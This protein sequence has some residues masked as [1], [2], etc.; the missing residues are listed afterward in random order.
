MKTKIRQQLANRKRRLERRLDKTNVPNCQRPR[1]TASDIHYEIANRTRGI[2]PT[3]HAEIQAAFGR[4]EE[5]GAARP[6]EQ[7]TRDSGHGRFEERTV[8]VLAAQ[9]LLPEAVGSA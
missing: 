6:R 5:A 2:S 8:R 9:G 4:A 1:F 3:L 7:V